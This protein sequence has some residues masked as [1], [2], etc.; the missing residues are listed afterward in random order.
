[1][2]KDL[3][4]VIIPVYN[5]EKYLIRCVDSVINQ[6]YKNLEIILV[7]DGS[8][9]S[10]GILCDDLA[11][12]DARIKVIHKENGGVSTAKN[13][14]FLKSRGN[15]IIF[16]DSDDYIEEIMIAELY[17][18]L[19]RED[20][21]VS[22]C[23]IMNEYTN[24]K[25][26][27]CKNTEYYA[28]YNKEKFIKEYLIGERV[29]G[30]LCNKLLSRRV[31]ENIVF[32]VGR[33]YE[34]AYYHLDLVESAKKYVIST[35]PYY[36]YYHRDKSLTSEKYSK[37]DLDCIDVYKR[38]YEYVSKNFLILEKEA[39]FRLSHSYF[40]VFDKMLLEDDYS[41]LEEYDN[42]VKFL[43][44]NAVKIFRN[45]IFRKGRRIAALALLIDV[46]LYRT[47]LIKNIEQSRKVH[48]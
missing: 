39:F 33:I 15:Y 29:P 42:V 44:R 19:I 24:S 27:Q 13:D 35:K 4:S 22:S 45:N 23:G 28:V 41:K 38:F 8:T 32:P 16:I 3:I 18:Q 20:A 37:R 46:R 10:S 34:D 21:D 31:V 47:L 7:N 25:I 6:T 30:S 5:V 48:D 1:M 17:T 9:D 12:G 43:R 11:K 26:P 2:D 36:H 40:V 14:G